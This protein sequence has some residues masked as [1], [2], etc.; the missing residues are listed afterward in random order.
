M[1]VKG[2]AKRSGRCSPLGIS[3]FVLRLFT[4]RRSTVWAGEGH[5]AS[6]Y[7]KPRSCASFLADEEGAQ[8]LPTRAAGDLWLAKVRWFTAWCFKI[9]G[10]NCFPVIWLGDLNSSTSRFLIGV[11]PAPACIDSEE[12]L[13]DLGAELTSAWKWFVIECTFSYSC[14]FDICVIDNKLVISAR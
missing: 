11:C 7:Q 6:C 10:V 1:A 14:W 2:E 9:F 3:M 13:P 12:G 8:K 5:G 4:W